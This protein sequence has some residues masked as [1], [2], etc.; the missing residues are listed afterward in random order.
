MFLF[1]W[2]LLCFGAFLKEWAG[3][4]AR[5]ARALLGEGGPQDT[6]IRATG[7]GSLPKGASVHHHAHRVSA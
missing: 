1:K 7:S 3:D 4:E 2:S 6:G 5:I